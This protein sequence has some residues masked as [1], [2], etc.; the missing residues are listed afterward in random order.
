MKIKPT[1]KLMAVLLAVACTASAVLAVM[2]ANWLIPSTV[3]ITAAPGIDVYN[4]DGTGLCNQIQW[5]DLQKG[6][7]K[8]WGIFIKNSKGTM[9]LYI[10]PTMSLVAHNLPSGVD[11]S[12]TLEQT[13]ALE[14]GQQT[15][16]IYIK[17]TATDSAIEGGPYSFTIEIKAFDSAQG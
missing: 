5:G 14:P 16:I 15:T 8:Q 3:T 2:V 4:A 17:L 10:I 1:W 7:T 6:T 11:L 13:V 9:T 12:W